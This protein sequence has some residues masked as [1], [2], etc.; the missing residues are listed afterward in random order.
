MNEDN[1]GLRGRMARQGEEAL[2]KVAQELLENPMVSRALSAT[3]E[4]RERATRAQELAMSALNLP[5]AGDLERLTRRL[6]SVSQR[7]ETIEDGLD[8]LEQ[9]IEQLG[10]SSAIDKR[11]AAIEE[12][13]A[14][15][16]AGIA[17]Q[18]AM[19]AAVAAE[20]PSPRRT[21]QSAGR[22]EG[23]SRAGRKA[24]AGQNAEAGQE[25][26]AGQG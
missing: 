7:L 12:L 10:S 11:L 26:G 13:L 23:R 18:S 14:R 9:R 17:E 1:R 3:F 22:S 8:R 2:G 21:R 19:P 24:E 4:A 16:E 20:T 15:L 5:S 6:R 25:P